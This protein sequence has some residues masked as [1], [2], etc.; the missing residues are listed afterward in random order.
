MTRRSPPLGDPRAAA[1]SSARHLPREAVVG[2]RASRRGPSRIQPGVLC[3]SAETTRDAR[4][5]QKE[6]NA[7]TRQS[8]PASRETRR[9]RAS[10][11][12]EEVEHVSP[13]VGADGPPPTAARYF[14]ETRRAG[15]AR[16]SRARTEGTRGAG[17]RTAFGC[18]HSTARM[19]PRTPSVTSGVLTCEEKV[20]S[21]LSETRWQRRRLVESPSALLSFKRRLSHSQARSDC[22][23]RATWG[24]GPG[25]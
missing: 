11:A 17:A 9:D 2:T 12:D 1:L 14:E 24:G 7:F 19:V 8:S 21:T 25:L 16:A 23:R 15:T 18:R 13:R 6:E 20:W 22:T 3:A 4:T 5:R 10:P